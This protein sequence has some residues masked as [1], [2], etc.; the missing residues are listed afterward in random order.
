MEPWATI[1]TCSRRSAGNTRELREPIGDVYAG[2]AQTHRAVVA[3]G[4][5]AAK[6]KELMALAIAVHDDCDCCIASHARGAARQGAT[7][8]EVAETIGVTIQMGTD[9]S[10]IYGPRAWAAYNDFAT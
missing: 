2:F 10:T 6:T 3:D 8:E 1:T 5:L 7:A 9:P 4:A